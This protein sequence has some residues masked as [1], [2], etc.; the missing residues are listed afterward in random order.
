MEPV[1]RRDFLRFG[2]PFCSVFLPVSRARLINSWSWG[3][4]GSTFTVRPTCTSK[5]PTRGSA[6]CISRVRY[7]ALGYR[8]EQTC[9]FLILKS[10]ERSACRALS[11]HRLSIGTNAVGSGWVGRRSRVTKNFVSAAL[12]HT[13][14][15]GFSLAV[16]KIVVLSLLT[17][18]LPPAIPC[19]KVGLVIELFLDTRGASRLPQE[20]R[21]THRCAR[22]N[23]LF[24]IDCSTMSR[25]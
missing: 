10:A 23:W 3:G 1:G 19:Q 8:A 2:S 16:R 9:F 24:N 7:G 15:L 6:L 25:G 20:F 4:V 18:L 11:L 22:S 13:P 17:V 21:R 5:G 12:F 14:L